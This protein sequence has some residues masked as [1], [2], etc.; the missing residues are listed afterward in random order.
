MQPCIEG[1]T[2][3]FRFEPVVYV[4]ARYRW[5]Y[6]GQRY[7]KL[8]DAGWVKLGRESDTLTD[9]ST[10]SFASSDDVYTS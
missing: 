8:S 4:P 5:D 9:I 6:K 7:R 3:G 10:P 2:R 1:F